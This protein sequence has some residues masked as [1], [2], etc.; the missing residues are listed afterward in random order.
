MIGDTVARALEIVGV[1][2]Q[3]IYQATGINCNCNERKERLNQLHVW[4]LRVL[5]GKVNRAREY[6]EQ[7]LKG[8]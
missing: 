4:A 6:L 5:S 2:E 1:T 8:T 7:I 3:S